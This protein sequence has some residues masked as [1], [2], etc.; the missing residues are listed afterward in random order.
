MSG[1]G[2]GGGGFIA[3]SSQYSGGGA[4]KSKRGDKGIHPVTI[5]QLLMATQETQDDSYMVDGRECSQVTFVGCIT[6]LEEASTV[7]SYTLEDCTGEITVRMWLDSEESEYMI[8]SRKEWQQGV[9]VRVVGNMKSQQGGDNKNFTAF[10][11]RTVKDFNE[12][13]YHLLDCC[14]AHLYNTRGAVQDSKP[15]GSSSFL[16]PSKPM[17]PQS[18]H[19]S[20]SM[21]Q[22]NSSPMGGG[23][24]GGGGGGITDMRSAIMEVFQAAKD[25]A[26]ESGVKLD[27]VCRQLTSRAGRNV[28]MSEVREHVDQLAMEGHIY[29]TLDEEHYSST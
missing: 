14:H 5:K 23:G 10:H 4:T 15:L 24:G 8:T 12:L 19:Q 11:I 22:N 7:V 26:N 6:Q 20:N 29:S 9:Y 13:T 17:L 21:P 16:S 3:E 18:M 2:E 1:Y 27:E 28:G 25:T